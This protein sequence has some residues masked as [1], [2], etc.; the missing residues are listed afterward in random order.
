MQSE[1]APEP[2]VSHAWSLGITT[3]AHFFWGRRKMRRW[4]K[5][6]TELD[7]ANRTSGILRD[8]LLTTNIIAFLSAHKDITAW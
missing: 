8:C 6:Y 5:L 3:V 2:R 7:S 4:W 1:T